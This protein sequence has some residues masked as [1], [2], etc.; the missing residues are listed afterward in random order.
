MQGG[1]RP[2]LEPVNDCGVDG[3]QEALASHPEVGSHWT[4]GEHHV[5]VVAHLQ[6]STVQIRP[7]ILT[8]IMALITCIAKAD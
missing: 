6:C 5:Q 8:C 1:F 3:G 7:V 4:G 2:R